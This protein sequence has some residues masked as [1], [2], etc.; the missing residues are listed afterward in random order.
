MAFEDLYAA[1]SADREAVDLSEQA[2]IPQAPDGIVYRLG[3]SSIPIAGM[4]DKCRVGRV[5][6]S[7]VIGPILTQ[8][9]YLRQRHGL[10]IIFDK[11][12]QLGIEVGVNEV[13]TICQIRSA[14][15]DHL[16]SAISNWR[17]EA[18]SSLGIL[19]AALDE[20]V[21]IEERFEDVITTHEGSPIGSADSRLRLRTFLPF[22][23]T[24]EERQSLAE[25]AELRASELVPLSEASR[26]YLK[27]AQ[28]G[29]TADAIVYLWIA[30][31]ALTPHKKTSPKTVE[32][33]LVIA[34]FNPDW[35][36]DVSIGHLAG[37][38]ADIVHKGAR[39]HPLIVDGYYRLETI[40]RVLI[41]NAAGVSSSWAP[42]LTPAVF[43]E[44]AAE[45]H[46]SRAARETVW[47]DD[48]LPPPEDPQPTGL[49]W[50]R[51]QVQLA[52]GIPPMEVSYRGEM[53]PGW[54]GRLNHW[55]ARAAEF[56]EVDFEPIE[57]NVSND[58]STAPDSIEMA[59]NSDGLLLRPGLFTL[60]DPNR[61]LSLAQR[62]QEGLAQIA[63]MRLGIASINFGTTLI[64]AGGS[65]AL[66]RAFYSRGG[67]FEGTD[68]KMN[69]ID[70][71]D[72]NGIGMALGA[73][74]AGSSAA[75]QT[76][77]ALSSNNES[78]PSQVVEA[79]LREWKGIET[80]PQLLEGIQSVADEFKKLSG[81]L[82]A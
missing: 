28:E 44:K 3:F 65:W 5:E 12:M 53:Q 57:I 61:E 47:H 50:N 79:L 66:Y 80:F 55:L 69:E 41:R 58:I 29:P 59:A 37:L 10:P 26:W 46:D 15:P 68:L 27:A 39:Q 31:E 35:L 52:D 24:A 43:G 76:L 54:R 33:M 7:R 21:A 70:A 32:A 77:V 81:E 25:L 14:P 36:G 42:T 30:V 23:V 75:A 72:L 51:V 9:T 67:P 62:L 49:T 19:A 40:V 4:P 63:V 56:L 64:A 11:S 78:G 2:S 48:S 73:A 71:D 6:I 34:G 16:G 60:P 17:E 1:L 18:R 20:R 13:L 8:R 22:D 38:R 82:P 45:I 74:L